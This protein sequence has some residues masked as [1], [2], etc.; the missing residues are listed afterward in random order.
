MV[1][2]ATG[3]L[4]G[5]PATTNKELFSYIRSLFPAVRW[6]G[7]ARWVSEGKVVTASGVTAGMDAA[8]YIIENVHGPAAAEA[9][10][11]DIEYSGNWRRSGDDPFAHHSSDDDLEADAS[12]KDLHAAEPLVA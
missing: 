3:L 9:A 2:A 4:D 11:R 7:H 1:L 10:A 6:Q 12:A 5:K 8:L